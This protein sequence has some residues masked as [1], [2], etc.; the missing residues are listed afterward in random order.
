M[1]VPLAETEALIRRARVRG[2]RCLLNMAPA[3]Q[4]NLGLLSEIDLLVA[5]KREATTLGPDL[6]RLGRRLRQALVVTRGARGAIAFLADGTSLDVPALSIEPVDTTGAGDAFT[7]A[8]AAGIDQ[9]LPLAAAL[10]RASAAGALT[11]LVRGAQS[12]LP[13][14]A[15]IDRAVI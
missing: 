7:G 3:L 9:G 5:N 1:E 2:G 13:D 8:L 12:A 14:K 10:Q 4:F 15:A 11:C 6:P